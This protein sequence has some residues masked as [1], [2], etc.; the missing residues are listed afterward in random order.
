[1]ER[2]SRQADLLP[3][4]PRV[5]QLDT[6]TLTFAPA[7][8][9]AKRRQAAALQT[10]FGYG[11]RELAPAFYSWTRLAVATFR[12]GAAC[13]ARRRCFA[14]VMDWPNTVLRG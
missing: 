1:M 5:T 6:A 7:G 2:G 10:G 4:P 9:D 8:T 11:V 14:M 13:C 12:R 3:L